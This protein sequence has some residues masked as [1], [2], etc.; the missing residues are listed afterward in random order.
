MDA[1]FKATYGDRL[2]VNFSP[3]ATVISIDGDLYRM[4]LPRFW[5]TG[6]FI[7][8]KRFFETENFIS[9]GFLSNIL[10]SLDSLTEPKAQMISGEA[11]RSIA[12]WFP[13]A[14]RAMYVLE[15]AS[16]THELVAESRSDLRTAV[17][18]LMERSDHYGNSKWASLQMAEKCLKAIIEL[19]GGQYDWT[20]KLTELSDH[21]RALGVQLSAPHL[22]NDIQ[23]NPKIR[24]RKEPCSREEA[25]AAHRAALKLVVD[26]VAAG[27][28]F[29]DDLIISQL[30]PVLFQ[31][32]NTT[33]P[34]MR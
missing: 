11:I 28:K 20:H 4:N 23:C 10:Q 24:Y 12:E 1:W 33:P 5:G 15:T 27:A 34:H 3:G 18:K 25:L 19:H 8:S 22:L 32:I 29:R 17:D 26:L 6:E 2:N 16:K 13:I 9:R 21:L 30:S 14:L 7:I 31:A